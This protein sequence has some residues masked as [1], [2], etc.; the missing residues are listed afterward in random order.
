MVDENPTTFGDNERA[1]IHASVGV[2]EA[3]DQNGRGPLIPWLIRFIF[4]IKLGKADADIAKG[5]SG[6]V[7]EYT[8]T[9]ATS[10]GSESDTGD[11]W[12]VYFRFG[13]VSSGK[14]VLFFRLFGHWEGIAAEC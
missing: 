9:D 3:G 14:W 10:P 13:A 7:S 6:T 5:A 4:Q 11:N 2:T 12:T 8:G 1:R